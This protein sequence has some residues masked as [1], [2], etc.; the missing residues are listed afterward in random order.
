MYRGVIG[1]TSL[2]QFRFVIKDGQEKWVKRDEFITVREAVT[3]K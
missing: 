1:T 2:R 3:Q